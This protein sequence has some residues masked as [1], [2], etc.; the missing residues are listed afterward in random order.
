MHFGFEAHEEE[1]EY[2]T[3]E[4]L[5][6]ELDYACFW[7]ESEKKAE[8]VETIPRKEDIMFPEL[9]S[10]YTIVYRIPLD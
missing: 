1:Y 7:L 2:H 8:I 6:E 9:A 5:P 4:C 3:E 10:S